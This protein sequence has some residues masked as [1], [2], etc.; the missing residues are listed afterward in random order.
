MKLERIVLREVEMPLIRFFETSFGRTTLRRILLV[1]AVSDG[2]SGWGEVT[3]G[4]NPFY[5]EEWTDGAWL[6]V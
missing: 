5:N 1:E 2:I 3:C 4:E 6:I